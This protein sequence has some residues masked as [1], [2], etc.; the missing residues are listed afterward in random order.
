VKG[1][2][3]L[4]AAFMSLR[5]DELDDHFTRPDLDARNVGV[6]EVSIID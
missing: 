2:V 5:L 6:D 1:E 3:T 4:C